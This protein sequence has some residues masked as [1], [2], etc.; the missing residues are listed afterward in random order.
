M[1]GSGTVLDC[2]AN[3]LYLARVVLWCADFC[4]N[5]YCVEVRHDGCVYV[6][7]VSLNAVYFVIIG[8]VYCD[9]CGL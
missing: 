6:L 7:S 8:V 3:T 4:L 1:A 5:A 9:Y 2:S